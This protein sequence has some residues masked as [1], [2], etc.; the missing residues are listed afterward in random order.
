MSQHGR[1]EV[2]KERRRRGRGTGERTRRQE[3]KPRRKVIARRL[4]SLRLECRLWS[5][6][7]WAVLCR[8]TGRL[9][10]TFSETGGGC[11]QREISSWL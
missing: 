9:S 1:K 8:I 6:A 10:W 5:D 2:R 11:I 7:K 4:R 3:R